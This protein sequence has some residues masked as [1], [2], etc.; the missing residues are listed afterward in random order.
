MKHQI[1]YHQNL[2]HQIVVSESTE[3][4]DIETTPCLRRTTRQRVKT[5]IFTYDE[6]GKSPTITNA[7]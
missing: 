1:I 6:L 5:K 7:S 3:D 2:Y 4:T